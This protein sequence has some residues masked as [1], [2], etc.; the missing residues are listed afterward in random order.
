MPQF[1]T[2][3]KVISP[4]PESLSPRTDA[5]QALVPENRGEEATVPRVS[6]PP[7]GSEETEVPRASGPLPVEEAPVPQTEIGAKGATLPQGPD[8]GVAALLADSTFDFLE[9]YPG[10]SILDEDEIAELKKLLP[11]DPPI[12]DLENSDD[13]YMVLSVGMGPATDVTLHAVPADIP[14]PMW[15]RW[16]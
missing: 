3:T 12:V 1:P 14:H 13:K 8:S 7:R 4:V 2:A 5:G 15:K 6:A 11:A 16:S 9:E 10:C